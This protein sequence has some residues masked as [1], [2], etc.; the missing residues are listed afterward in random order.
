[1]QENG[2]A[3]DVTFCILFLSSISHAKNEATQEGPRVSNHCV[4]ASFKAAEVILSRFSYVPTRG[5]GVSRIDSGQE[6]SQKLSILILECRLLKPCGLE[7]LIKG[8]RERRGLE[9]GG[10]RR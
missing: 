7:E 3:F 1:M 5:D 4:Y 2:Q 9:K 10:R 6:S 8:V